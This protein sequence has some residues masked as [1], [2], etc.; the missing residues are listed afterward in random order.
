MEISAEKLAE[1]I[2][3]VRSKAENNKDLQAYIRPSDY[4][5][6]TKSEETQEFMNILKKIL[7]I[8]KIEIAGKDLIDLTLK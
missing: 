5:F 6:G 1:I 8:K 3:A 7:N 4:G 2:R